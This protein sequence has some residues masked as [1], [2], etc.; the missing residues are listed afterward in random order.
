VNAL[1]APV[2]GALWALLAAACFAAMGG[3]IRHLANM[4]IHPL[5]TGFYRSV[6]GM[7]LMA[8]FLIRSGFGLMRTQRHGLFCLRGIASGIGQGFYF[9]GI[10][11][12]PMADAISL[13]FT[14]PL[15]GTLLAVVILGEVLKMR[16]WTATL[17]GFAGVLIVLR[18]GFTAVTALTATPLLAAM[19]MAFIWI[20]VKMLARTEP[21][22]RIVFYMMAY[23]VPV[24]LVPALFVWTTPGWEHAGWLVATSVIAKLGQFAMTNA[25]RAAEATA[26][27][28]YDFARL[29]FT[30]L[31][32]YFG[33]AQA[34]DGWTWLGGVVIFGSTVYIMRRE[35]RLGRGR[36]Q[37]SD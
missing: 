11:F 29:P 36:K 18:P 2:R 19:S 34:P 37:D 20:F 5:V 1:P 7:A 31:I 10:A 17:I 24:T 6:I 3:G 27:F 13:T 22:E 25:Y 8:P 35:A 26:V 15:F 4:D 23:T 28:P 12:L 16:R 14:A 30:A 32:A 9:V 33:F 21:T